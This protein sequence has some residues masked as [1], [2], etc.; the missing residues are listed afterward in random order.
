MTARVSYDNNNTWRQQSPKTIRTDPESLLLICQLIP[1]VHH[2]STLGRKADIEDRRKEKKEAKQTERDQSCMPSRLLEGANTHADQSA[3][4]GRFLTMME[5]AKRK[6][7]K[8]VPSGSMHSR[9]L[10]A[11][12]QLIY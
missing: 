5:Q 2:G 6:E 7:Q 8:V 1:Q 11:N 4:G 10:K 12:K 3:D 9:R